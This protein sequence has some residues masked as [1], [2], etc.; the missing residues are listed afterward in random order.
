M[1]KSKKKTV[2]TERAKLKRL[3]ARQGNKSPI[4]KEINLLRKWAKEKT[5]VE[6]IVNWQTIAMSH[7]GTIVELDWSEHVDDF[8]FLS[9]NRTHVL[10]SPLIWK[11]SEVAESPFGPALHLGDSTG[12]QTTV[13][14]RATP[15]AQATATAHSQALEQLRLWDR[16]KTKLYVMLNQGAYALSLV[17]LATELSDGVFGFTQINS[18]NQMLIVVDGYQKSEVKDENGRRTVHLI[19]RDSGS[20]IV[21]DTPNDPENVF[22][23]FD[24]R[25]S[26]IH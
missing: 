9:N 15:N 3:R 18:P 7:K 24:L 11:H 14:L 2:E 5:E 25:S 10:L 6:L 23:Q 22:K 17:G 12:L 21:S 16:L 1:K 4:D 19:S 8:M 20:C 26:F 13:T